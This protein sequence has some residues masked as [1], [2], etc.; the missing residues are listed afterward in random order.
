VEQIRSGPDWRGRAVLVTG[1]RGFIATHLCRRLVREG[2]R[3]YGVS[4][5][6]ASADVPD[7]EWVR[8]DFAEA[9]AA[10]LVFR[11]TRPDIVFHLAGHVTGS[12]D[13]AN[14]DP[15][16]LQNLE[17]TVRL[18]TAAV[19]TGRPRVVLA[20]SMQ[21]PRADEPGV[22]PCSPY[23]ASKWACSVYARMF[24][25]LY[26]LPVTIAKPFMVFGPGQWDLKKLLPYV[27]VSLLRGEIPSLG[28]GLRELDWVYVDDV[29]DGLLAAADSPCTDASPIDLG[30]GQLTSVKKMI[31]LVG[32]ALD[33]KLPVQ[34]GAVADRQLERAHAARAEDTRRLIG[35]SA[36]TS[37]Q[38]GLVKTIDWYRAQ[39]AVGSL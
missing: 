18:M 3:V 30:S 36:S 22:I 7:V 13:I 29:V 20:A 32:E 39:V 21:E 11:R 24:H 6:S 31:E 37:L 33:C 25:A 38:T 1:A 34:F 27:I 15:T 16:L 2:A 17:S 14:V 4:R 35:W 26:G 23:A 5:A 28:S 19:E 10:G 8:A 9:S 12:Q